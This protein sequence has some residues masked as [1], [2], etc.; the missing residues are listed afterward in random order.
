MM[1]MLNLIIKNK[2]SLKIQNH[3]Q[4]RGRVEDDVNV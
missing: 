2:V 3:C 4:E 1:K